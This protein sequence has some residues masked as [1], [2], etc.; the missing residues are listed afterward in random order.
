M[1]SFPAPGRRRWLVPAAL[2]ALALVP[3]AA[4]AAR[5]A[6]LSGGGALLPEPPHAVESPLPL[7]VHIVSAVVFTVLGAFQFVPGTRGRRPA[8]HRTT[9]RLAAPAGLLAALSGLWLTLVITDAD[10]GLLTVFRASAGAGMGAAIVLGVLAVLRRDLRRHRAWMLRGYAL[11]IGAGTQVFTAGLGA[12]VVGEPG[13]TAQALLMG[14]GWA[15][16]LAVA[17]WLIR[18]RPRRP[19]PGR[20][21]PVRV[22][23]EVR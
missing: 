7:V 23:E 21:T 3:I 2:I 8:W 19:A 17:E 4:G 5:L 12:L 15:I 9:G 1:T 13:E 11:G 20:P 18:R 16:N 22:T 10:G 14:A 6:E